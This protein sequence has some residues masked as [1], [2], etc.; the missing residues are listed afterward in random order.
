MLVKLFFFFPD[1]YAS[2]LSLDV[3]TTMIL[4]PGP[5]TEFLKAN[6]GVR[7]NRFIDWVKVKNFL[8]V[9]LDIIIDLFGNS[10]FG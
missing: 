9:C 5:V 3:S 10:I 6:Q 8:T 1:I 2:E 4:R 7:E